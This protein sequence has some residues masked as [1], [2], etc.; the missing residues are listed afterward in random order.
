MQAPNQYNR[1]NMNRYN[2][3][4]K[5]FYTLPLLLLLSIGGCVQEN[6]EIPGT[7]EP[8]EW[9]TIEMIVPEHDTPVARSIEDNQ[10]EAI[11]QE[12]DLM[13]FDKATIPNLLHH[14]KATTIRQSA[15]GPYYKVSFDAPLANF[16]NAGTIAVIANASAEVQDAMWG[17]YAGTEGR[18]LKTSLMAWLRFHTTSDKGRYEWNVSTPGFTPIPMYGE[19]AVNGVTPGMKITGLELTR[20]LARI[21][22]ENKVNGTLFQ[23]QEIYLVNYH[24]GGFIAP[25]WDPLTGRLLKEGDAG[26][27]YLNDIDPRIPNTAT[28]PANTREAAMKYIYNQKND[29]P[30]PLL[31][32]QIYAYEEVKSANMPESRI[33]LILK[34]RYLNREYYYRVDFTT[35]KKGSLGAAEVENIPLYRNHKYVVTI[36][37]AEGIGYESF[38]EA[39]LSQTVLSNLKTSI[40]V[41]DMAGIN[42]IVFDGQYF[43]GVETKNINI[44]WKANAQI[45]HRVSS[46][47]K[48]NWKAE[49][50][51]PNQTTWLRL[52]GNQAIAYGSD[53][54]QSGVDFFVTPLA[55]LGSGNGHTSGKIEI[56]AGRLRD[57]LTVSRVTLV[58]LFARSNIVYRSG[59]LTFA[60]TEQ[61]NQV[62]P[63]WSQGVFFKWG[64]LIAQEPAGNPYYPGNH[65]VYYPD[66]LNPS[67]WGN[68]LT[69]WDRIPYAHP[70]FGFSAVAQT[71]KE[72][73]A[74]SEYSNQTGFNANAGIG[75]ICRYISSGTGGKMWVEGEWRL[76]TEAEWEMLFEET[77][78]KA[79]PI[80]NFTNQTGA[81]N[82]S[83]NRNGTFNPQSGW[84]VGAGV[85]ASTATTTHMSSPPAHTAFLPAAGHRYPNGAGEIVQVG[86]YGYYWSSTPYTTYSVN[87]P[88]L[89]AGEMSF[90]D[91]D[92]SYAFPVRCIRNK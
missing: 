92:R 42:D 18:T 90:N 31:A 70:N 32:G 36:T 34:G 64:S 83:T 16:A 2:L 79:A 28:V 25:A 78:G 53:I 65:L 43:M 62:I 7:E 30:G 38:E 86:A 87:Y 3:W 15:Q 52:S 77:G 75:D 50:I 57:T 60:V 54:N 76:P 80:G 4:S 8:E 55:S 89:S 40:L 82:V 85:T 24:T 45:N 10:G 6:A 11:V 5:L 29:A 51:D 12:I 13:I 84:F 68:G 47:Y 71:D 1:Y 49:I 72:T 73:D 39:V 56:T 69:G 41:V 19:V 21:D 67:G 27:P 66:G 26:Y 33:C 58:D 59:K 20:M 35:N 17:W 48:G 44:S 81:L 14:Y 23:L 74:F 37:A 63:A 61:D 46:N 88:F 9:V 22:V 91:A